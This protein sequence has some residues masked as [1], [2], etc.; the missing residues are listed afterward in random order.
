MKNGV[1]SDMHNYALKDLLVH[2]SLVSREY[3]DWAAEMTEGTTCTWLEQ[4]L[5]VGAVDEESVCRCIAQ[6]ACVPRCEPQRLLELS[7]GALAIV[8]AE[9]AVEHR[10][11]S[12]GVDREGYLHLVMVDPTDAA[13]LAEVA[14]FSGRGL[15]RQI[16]VAGVIAWALD[17]Y[18]GAR[19]VLWPRRPKQ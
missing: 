4:L 16:A 9:V 5:L 19:T 17:H 1:T 7:P 3:I 13:A 10:L 2:R 12:R 11:I 14:F 6:T 18:Y 8:P 15:I